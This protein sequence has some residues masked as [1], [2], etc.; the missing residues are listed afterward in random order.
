MTWTT[1][2]DIRAQVLR[3]WEK[4]A[5]LSVLID[6][7]PRFPLQLRLKRP[8]SAELSS[9]F[10]EVQDWAKAL[11]QASKGR[12]RIEYRTVRHRVIGENNV[13]REIWLDT[14]D[15]ALAIIGKQHDADKFAA[16]LGETTQ[17]F[18]QLVPWLARY[19]L[20][21]LAKSDDWPHLLDVVAWVRAHPQPNIYLR[22]VDIPGVHSKFIE[23]HRTTLGQLLDRVLAP[24]HIDDTT[25]RGGKE[26]NRRFGFRDK[27]PLVRFRVIDDALAIFAP[28]TEQDITIPASTLA[29]LTR[30]PQRVFITE[31]ETNFLAFPPVPQS[32]VIFGGGYGFEMLS[33]IPWLAD[34]DIHYWGDIDTHGFVILDQLRHRLPHA[35]SLFMDRAT[36]LQHR[37]YWHHESTP[38]SR[39]LSHLT[40]DETALYDDLRNNRLGKHLRL[41]Q[42]RVRFSWI[43]EHLPGKSAD[44]IT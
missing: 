34:C 22:Q 20:K 18:P 42:E 39:P 17:R 8:T 3:L 44:T 13:P 19:P 28:G 11:A 25:T 37:D 7:E 29:A 16:I 10:A 38:T 41:E 1:A 31:N 15:D 32:I 33:D 5:L 43:Q 21:T 12:Y 26:F 4:G 9:A 24:D 35:Q 36:L 14:L 30:K 6:D 2:A 23:G 40:P 27:P